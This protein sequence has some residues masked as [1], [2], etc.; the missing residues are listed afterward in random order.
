[1]D[2]LTF[3]RLGRRLRRLVTVL[4]FARLR[5]ATDII[6]IICIYMLKL[7][8]IR[9]GYIFFLLV[10]R[11]KRPH[12]VVTNKPKPLFLLEFSEKCFDF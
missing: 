11:L 2:L 3:L 7:I 1:M 4:V 9:T 6:I 10:I 12:A 8:T 5:L